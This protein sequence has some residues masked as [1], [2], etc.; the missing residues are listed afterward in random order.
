MHFKLKLVKSKLQV[1][2]K[3]PCV[4]L[5]KLRIHNAFLLGQNEQQQQPKDCLKV[6]ASNYEVQK[7]AVPCGILM[8][9]EMA[10]EPLSKWSC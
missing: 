1:S 9:W 5:G 6:W 10:Y 7:F 8:N 3:W 2:R 4:D